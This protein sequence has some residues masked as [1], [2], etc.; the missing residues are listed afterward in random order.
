[1]KCAIYNEEDV[2]L[3]TIENIPFPSGSG[4]LKVNKYVKTLKFVF[5]TNFDRAADLPILA[6]AKIIG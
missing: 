2:L 1:V 6:L 5:S 4:S 3:G